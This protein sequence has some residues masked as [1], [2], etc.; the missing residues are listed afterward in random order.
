[1]RAITTELSLDTGGRYKLFIMAYVKD[2]SLDIFDNEVHTEILQRMVPAEFRDGHFPNEQLLREWHPKVGE[3]GV[4][5]Q[6]YQALQ[7]FS[8]TFHGFD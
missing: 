4:Q 3:H 2:Q 7:I 8:F 1:M 6:M 5:D